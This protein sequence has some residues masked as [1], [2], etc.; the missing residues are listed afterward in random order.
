M[1]WDLDILDKIT[2]WGTLCVA[3]PYHSSIIQMPE[4][5]EQ[6]KPIFTT[7]WCSITHILNTTQPAQLTCGLLLLAGSKFKLTH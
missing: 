3:M 5:D 4:T 7:K 2:A 1:L 6:F